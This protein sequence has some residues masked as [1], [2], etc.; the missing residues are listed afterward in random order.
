MSDH[1]FFSFIINVLDP[2]DPIKYL[3]LIIPTITIVVTFTT[4]LAFIA[5]FYALII[6]YTGILF[7]I[8]C[9]N[10]DELDQKLDKM[11]EDAVLSELRTVIIAHQK[12]IKW[13]FLTYIIYNW[14][15]I[16]NNNNF[17]TARKLEAATNYSMLLQ[18]FINSFFI[19]LIGFDIFAVKFFFLICFNKA[20]TSY[21]NQ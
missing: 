9:Y 1:P 10:I 11:D 4:V 8:I 7:R 3:M 19:C 20:K 6:Y 12:A 16:G 17:R 13:G 5:L 15:K 18:V 21:L 2:F 14:K